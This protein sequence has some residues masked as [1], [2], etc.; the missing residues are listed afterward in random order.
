MLKL[1]NKH[2]QKLSAALMTGSIMGFSSAAFAGG[3]AGDFDQYSSTLSQRVNSVPDVV[4][5]L[6]YLT[7]AGLAALGVAS[8]KQHVEQGNQGKP[9]K[10]GLAKLGFGGMLIAVPTISEVM[11]ETA[12]EG[13]EATLM[14]FTEQQITP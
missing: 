2:T 11:L 4:S 7:G 10:D 12:N 3:N 13:G 6:S 9:L 5:F 14:G 1:L 8:L